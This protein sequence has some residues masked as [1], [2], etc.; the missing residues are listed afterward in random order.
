MTNPTE[1]KDLF[2]TYK[3]EGNTF[4]ET[5]DVD[6]F[7]GRENISNTSVSLSLDSPVS[8][9]GAKK[10]TL[11]DAIAEAAAA[12]DKETWRGSDNEVLAAGLQASVE[13]ALLNSGQRL[14]KSV[15][16]K[17]NGQKVTMTAVNSK[18][19]TITVTKDIYDSVGVE[20]KGIQA[21]ASALVTEFL[22]NIN[23]DEDYT[24]GG[25]LDYTNK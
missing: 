18:G 9:T 3:G 15:K 7:S 10:I 22:S 14:D 2:D 25:A 5:Y 16:V 23:S 8:G 21:E 20:A 12:A 13:Q 19:K 6:A 17:A 1:T 11:N 24:S 4:D